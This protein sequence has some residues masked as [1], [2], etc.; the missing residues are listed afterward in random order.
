VLTIDERVR[1]DGTLETIRLDRASGGLEVSVGAEPAVA[2][3]LHALE[4]VM[5]RYARPLADDVRAEGP[6]LELDDGR[7]LVMLRHLARY[8]VIARDF[9]VFERPGA[10]AVAELATSIAAP[11]VHLARAARRA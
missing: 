3:T 6:R 1:D 2:L 8:D 5:D 11:I 4:R 9:L 10:P 7:A